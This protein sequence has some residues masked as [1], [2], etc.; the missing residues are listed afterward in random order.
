[1]ENSQK[2]IIIANPIYDVVFKSLMTTDKGTNKDIASFFLGT[3][4]DEEITDIEILP[5]EYTYH[6][7]FKNV[8]ETQKNNKLTLI[9]LDFIATIRTKSGEY[10]KILIELQKSQ[11]STDQARFRT[12]LGE[13][14]K[15]LNTVILNDE[16]IEQPLPIILIYMFGYTL[17]GCDSIVTSV[18][19]SYYSEDKK[20]EIKQKNAFIESLTHDAF[21]IQIPRI[22]SNIFS[23][24]ELS[25]DMKMLLSLFE[26]NYFVEGNYT[27]KYIYP[28][29]NKNI[30][31]MIDTLEFIQADPK[32]RRAMQEEYWV[33]QNEDIWE[34]KVTSL[35]D[36]VVTLTDRNVTLTNENVTLV[37]ENVTLTDKNVTL[38][39]ENEELRRMLLQAGLKL[40]SSK[41]KN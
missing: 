23:N 38:T 10:K 28:I 32:I 18:K 39:N 9:R 41:I 31:K 2:D 15:L 5:Q 36:K 6:P 17:T 4:L 13:Q 25:E 1:M 21:F 19:H 27:K 35:N 40:P 22:D 3:I 8:D 34:K 26:Q 7:K 14:Y 29:T 20:S 24:S 16:K 12:Y 33:A 30:K 37:N 11:K